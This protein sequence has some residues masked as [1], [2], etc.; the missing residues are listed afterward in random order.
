MFEFKC[1]CPDLSYSNA[2]A[3][4]YFYKFNVHSLKEIYCLKEIAL[5][6]FIYLKGYS[7]K[8]PI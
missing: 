5:V 4:Y 7:T 1:I 2:N 6:E 8:V 3:D